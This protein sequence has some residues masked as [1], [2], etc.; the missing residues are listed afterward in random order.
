Q[1]LD[2]GF[3]ECMEIASRMYGQLE[4]IYQG[5]VEHSANAPE[6]LRSTLQQPINELYHAVA[7]TLFT[8]LHVLQPDDFKKT[9]PVNFYFLPGYHSCLLRR[10]VFIRH[11]SSDFGIGISGFDINQFICYYYCC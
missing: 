9:E 4:S 8:L 5:R 1:V 2:R 3:Q 10:R 7:T 11:E 6:S